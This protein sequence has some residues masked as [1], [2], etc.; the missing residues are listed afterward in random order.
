MNILII[1]TPDSGKSKRAEELICHLAGDDPKIYIATMVPFDEEG[2]KRIKK[3]RA[4]RE[5]KGFETIECPVNLK[6]LETQLSE[7]RSPNCL[8]EC[9]SNLVGNEMYLRDNAVL[10]DSELIELIVSEV[11]AL[12]DMAENTV[13]VSNEF[14]ISEDFD[15]ETVR[16]VR[17][18]HEVNERL[19]Q[20]IG[21][22]EILRAPEGKEE[23]K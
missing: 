15:E 5:G 20:I 10:S 4:M 19:S 12:T 18:A 14:E 7:Y 11:K 6:T 1:G 21:R 16:Y 17:L 9:M 3:H 23:A 13:I 22:V 2:K 8:L